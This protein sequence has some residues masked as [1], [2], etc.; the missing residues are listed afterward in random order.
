MDNEFVYFLHGAT[1]RNIDDIYNIFENGLINNTGTD[2]KSSM[3][4]INR[5]GCQI[6]D[7]IKEHPEIK[8]NVIFVIR[9]PL[10]YLA[11]VVIE[12][13]AKQTPVPIWK[14]LGKEEAEL[15]PELVY[16]VYI[17]HMNSLKVNPN[18]SPVFDPTGLQFDNSQI[19][20]LAKNNVV[21]W[22]EGALNRRYR[23]YDDLKKDDEILHRFDYAM[24]F[25]NTHFG[26]YGYRK[27]EEKKREFGKKI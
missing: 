24:S 7:K 9:I 25:Y 5:N 26:Y 2:M 16:G 15:P 10:I 12:G 18:Y 27:S 17:K 13:V 6:V 8:G 22:Q 1:V 19:E 21:G 4:M 23:S 20:Y 14:R 11:P 3:T